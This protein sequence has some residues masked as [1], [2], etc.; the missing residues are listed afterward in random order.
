[1]RLIYRQTLN[2]RNSASLIEIKNWAQGDFTQ[3]FYDYIDSK[4]NLGKTVPTNGTYGSVPFVFYRSF[5]TTKDTW[6]FSIYDKDM[7]ILSVNGVTQFD[8][9]SLV[10]SSPSQWAPKFEYGNFLIGFYNPSGKTFE[11]NDLPL[12]EP[13]Y[14]GAIWE[15][16]TGYLRIKK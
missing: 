15:D 2:N 8:L 7:N 3:G 1:L 6:S 9:K 16:A 14:K 13:D 11:L 4:G 5:L 10:Y 12:S